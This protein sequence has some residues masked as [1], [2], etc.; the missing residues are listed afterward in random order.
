MLNESLKLFSVFQ[1]IFQVFFPDVERAEWF[2][3]VNVKFLL[4]TWNLYQAENEKPNN[5]ERIYVFNYV[6]RDERKLHSM[7]A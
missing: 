7:I 5:N 3:K 4:F 1:I 2:N 6:Y